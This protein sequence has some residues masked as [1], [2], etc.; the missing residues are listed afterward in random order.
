[1]K[2]KKVLIGLAIFFTLIIV[3]AIVIPIIYKDDIK[4]TIDEQLEANLNAD[5]LFDIDNFSVSLFSNFPNLTAGIKEFG[6][7]GRAPFAGEVLFAANNFEVEVNLWKLAFGSEI[8]VQGIYLDQPQI[9]IKVLEDGS[10]NYDVAIS[11]DEPSEPTDETSA[12]FNFAID[13]WEINKG[14]II[15]DDATIPT[16]VEFTNFDHSGAGNFSLS[17]FDL[18]TASKTHLKHLRY[19]GTE[20]LAGQEV[21]LDLI[22]NMD[23]DK[24]KFVFKQNA[25]AVNNFV[26]GFDGWLAMPGDDIDM[27]LTFESQNNSFK[28][29]ISLIPSM[30]LSDFSDLKS[31]G[32]IKFDGAISGTYNES[33]MPA[34]N[35][36]LLV[37]DGMFQYPDLP[38]AVSNV[39]LK[40]LV[41]NIDGNIDNTK[42]DISTF[43]MELGNNPVDA[44]LKIANLIDYP[45]ELNAS[46]EINFAEMMQMFPMEGMEL[47]GLLAADLEIIGIYD[48][49]NSTIP[50][51]GKFRLTDFSYVDEEYLPQGMSISNAIASFN[52]ENINLE[53]FDSKIGQSDFSATGELSNYLNYALKPDAVLSGNLELNSNNILVDEFMTSSEIEEESSEVDSVSMSDEDYDMSIPTNIDFTM[54]A[55]LGKIEYDGLLLT[56]AKGVLVVRD[57]I[58]DMNNLSTKTLDGEIVFNGSYN[59]QDPKDPKFDMDLGIKKISIPKSFKAFNTVQKFAPIAENMQGKISTDFKITGDLDKE[60]MPVT[61]TINGEAILRIS[62]ATLKGGSFVTSLSKIISKGGKDEMNLKNIKM[63]VKITNGAVSV[64]PFDLIVDSYKSKISGNTSLEGALNYRIET[65]LPAGELGQQANAALA[66]ILGGTQEASSEIKLNLGVTGQYDSPKISIMSSD[67]KEQVTKAAVTK[68]VD[69]VKQNTGVDLPT[70]KEELNKEAIEKAKKEADQILAQAQKQADQLKAEARKTADDIRAE[71]KIQN[72]KLIKEAGSNIF[73][74]KAAEIAG[75]KLIEEADKQATKIEAEGTK[76]ADGVMAKAQEKADALIKNAESK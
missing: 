70:S 74:K 15:Y 73:K 58:L 51:S 36:N 68:A 46:A 59:T 29:L 75:E 49:L 72:D 19:D 41:E 18:N 3:S 65:S 6:I 7:V 40:M 60:M 56:D 10:A 38:E 5:L 47:K 39:Q 62:E 8:S 54:K 37:D 63:D 12:D 27:D 30:Y 4:R 43:H 52:P 20:Y 55:N 25:L 31:S 71:A 44:T 57:G 16:Y 9:F 66:N 64:A 26:F 67:A 33:S 22:M 28:S 32:E 2:I 23:I 35:I 1:M 76:Q 11:A 53:A 14:H 50:A 13:K 21:S 69:L 34:F 42:I 61:E 17:V 45:I 24:M 48:T